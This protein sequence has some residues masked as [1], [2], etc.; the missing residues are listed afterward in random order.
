[1]TNIKFYSC[2]DCG[3]LVETIHD[4]GIAPSCCGM[5]MEC[6]SPNTA[7][8]SGE[9]HV[10]V[11][12]VKDGEVLVS[13]GSVDHPMQDVHYIEWIQLVTERSSIRRY[14]KPSETPK[15][16]FKLEGEKPVAVYAY[17]NLH[18]LWKTDLI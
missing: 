10:P 8:A 7:D 6:L 1:M 2:P 12:T 17:C 18:G 11:V 13:V 3:L 14:L 15:T 9:K 16:V 4:S 5:K